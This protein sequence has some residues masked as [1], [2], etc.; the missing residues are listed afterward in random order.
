MPLEKF[1]GTFHRA[2]TWI[3]KN[4]IAFWQWYF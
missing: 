3:S 1:T 2:E 4:D